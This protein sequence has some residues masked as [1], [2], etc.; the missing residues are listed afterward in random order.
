MLLDTG[1]L[2]V[3]SLKGDAELTVK[4][5]WWKQILAE[6]PSHPMIKGVTWL[7]TNR[8]EPE[9]GGRVADWR[10]T[11]VPGIAGSFRTDLQKAGDVVFLAKGRVVEHAPAYEFFDA[12]KTN[13]AA[14]FLRGDLVI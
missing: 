2:Y 13:E 4:Q 5:G 7:E 10:E 8:T 3:H 6:L 1:A 9:A 12:P 14:A 11:A